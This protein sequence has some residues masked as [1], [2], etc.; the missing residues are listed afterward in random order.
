MQTLLGIVAP[1][2]FS[3]TLISTGMNAQRRCGKWTGIRP[4]CPG[5]GWGDLKHRQHTVRLTRLCRQ[6]C[7]TATVL[8]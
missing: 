8:I 4:A 3:N 1:P 5:S 7:G 2:F 6:M